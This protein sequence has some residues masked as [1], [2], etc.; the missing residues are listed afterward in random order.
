MIIAIEDIIPQK[1][2]E[3]GLSMTP[4]MKAASG[5]K[6][7]HSPCAKPAIWSPHL[8]RARW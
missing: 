8:S 5:K 7:S 4:F 3:K 2:L 1:L 6:V